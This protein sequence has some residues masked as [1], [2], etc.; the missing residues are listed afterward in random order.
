MHYKIYE[1]HTLQ[2]LYLHHSLTRHHETLDGQ[3]EREAQNKT[4]SSIEKNGM[5]KMHDADDRCLGPLN[6]LFCCHRQLEA[7][8][9]VYDHGNERNRRNRQ[10]I[11]G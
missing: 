2:K 10:K 6:S 11:N 8:A 7:R 1:F 5:N 3:K 9:R 4:E